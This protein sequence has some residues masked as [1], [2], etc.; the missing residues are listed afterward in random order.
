MSRDK[1]Y[2]KLLN[3][4]RWT[5]LRISYLRAH[6]L[7]ERCKA[8]GYVRSAIDVHHRQPVETAHTL[9]E[10]ERLCYDWNNLQALCI[11][12]HVQTHKEM[13][14]NTRGNMQA[15]A[16]ARL[17]RWKDGV[18]AMSQPVLPPQTPAGS[19]SSKPCSKRKSPCRVSD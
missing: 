17:E 7:C 12:C 11:P 5:E 19:F 9:Q 13:G 14:K 10:M 4:K 6:P 3:S 16:A 18:R 8:E 1:R 15:R 2:Q